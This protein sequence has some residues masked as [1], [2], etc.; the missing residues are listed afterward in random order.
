[1]NAVVIALIVSAQA[2][3]TVIPLRSVSRIEFVQDGGAILITAWDRHALGVA[4][5]DA[6][7]PKH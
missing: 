1:M 7:A 3:D 4:D 6:A 2:Q 5:F